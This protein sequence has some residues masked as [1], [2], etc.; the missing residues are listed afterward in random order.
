MSEN[1]FYSSNE[2][3]IQL[4]Q[5]RYDALER[6]YEIL[7]KTS[8]TMNAGAMFILLATLKVIENDHAYALSGILLY[9]LGILCSF[10]SLI[11]NYVFLYTLLESPKTYFID[12]DFEAGK[13]NKGLGFSAN[14]RKI[15]IISVIISILLFAIASI[16]IFNGVQS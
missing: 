8:I 9:I 4:H 7:V 11:F 6:S 1:E 2:F 3:R 10:V 13:I 5:K 16:L 12:V 15:S 14:F